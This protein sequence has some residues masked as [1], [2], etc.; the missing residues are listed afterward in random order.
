MRYF[1]DI[2]YDV[3]TV[4]LPSMQKSLKELRTEEKKASSIK[5][6]RKQAFY[7]KDKV[8]TAMEKL[9]KPADELEM[10]VD[11]KIWPIPT[12]GDLM[13]DV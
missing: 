1:I 5:D 10:M 11:K 6:Q 7:Y 2:D 12:Y 9:R 3:L 13:F 8:N 4:K